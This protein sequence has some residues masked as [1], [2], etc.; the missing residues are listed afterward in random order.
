MT[1][2]FSLVAY[3][4]GAGGLFIALLLFG[5][6][7]K[8]VWLIIVALLPLFAAMILV[9]MAFIEVSAVAIKAMTNPPSNRTAEEVFAE[10]FDR[11]QT[12]CV[13]IV[14]YHDPTVKVLHDKRLICFSACPAETRRIL[15]GRRY[16]VTERATTD[17]ITAM[18]DKCCQ[19][20]VTT[21]RFGARLWDCL[22]S[23]GTDVYTMYVSMDSTR[24]YYIREMK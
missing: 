11:P 10:E 12:P 2:V 4:C 18:S 13:Q 6:V 24:V 17:V 16:D 14:D 19:S 7:R 9:Y 23:E 21:E 20:F 15:T 3:A 1:G 5:I 8:K 22:A